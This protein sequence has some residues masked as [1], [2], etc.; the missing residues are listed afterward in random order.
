MMAIE[1]IIHSEKNTGLRIKVVR[2]LLR[3][4]TEVRMAEAQMAQHTNASGVIERDLAG[5]WRT[6]RPVD[7]SW[8]LGASQRRYREYYYNILTQMHKT[9][10]ADG[11][12]DAIVAAALQA[13]GQSTEKAAE[14]A[15]WRA[16][17][18]LQ[19]QHTRNNIEAKRDLLTLITSWTTAGV[20]AGGL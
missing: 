10:A 5:L 14:F 15:D 11:D 12:L 20:V 9:R 8:W 7:V 19:S 2:V 18:E 1:Y 17:L 3:Q 16:K 13:I 4:D 6:G